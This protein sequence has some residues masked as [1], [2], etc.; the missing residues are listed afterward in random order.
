M[1]VPITEKNI[2]KKIII[3][4]SDAMT[5]QMGDRVAVQITRYSDKKK[6][7]R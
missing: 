3:A 7:F 1:C 6:D 4:Q 5:A 2:F